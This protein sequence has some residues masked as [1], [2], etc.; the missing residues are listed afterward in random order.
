MKKIT[1][2]FLLIAAIVASENVVNAASLADPTTAAPTPPARTAAKV[3][4]FF[5]DAYAPV[6]GINFNPGWGQNTVVSTIQ[7]AGNNTLKY[8]GLNYQGTEFP[9]VNALT[10]NKL[11]IDVWTADGT[12]LQITPISVGPKENLITLTP[13]LKN[14]WNS[15]D[16]DLGQFTGVV[17]SE[18]FQFKIVG[19]GTVY[20]DNLYLYDNTATVD[21]EAPTALTAIKGAVTSD[22][23]ELL[24]N[25]T[26]NSGAVNF[27]ITYGTTKLTV[28]GISGV[29]KSYT[30]TGLL[31]GTDYSFSIVAK[32]ITGNTSANAVI[33]TAKTATSIAAAPTPTRPAANVIS[34][35]SDAH[36]NVT[37]T[38]FFPGWGQSTVATQVQ[39]APDNSSLKYANLNYQGIELGSHVNASAMSKLHIDVYTENE[40]A[41]Q[42]TPISTGK[43]FLVALS[44]LVLNKWNSY[45]IPL[46]S[47][48]GVVMSD[49]FQFK[50]VGSGVK[51]VY[52]D[53]LY[54]HDGTTAVNEVYAD[55]SIKIYPTAVSK[56]L[57]IKSEKEMSQVLVCN[58]LGQTLK[59]ITVTGLEKTI[60][61]SAI[62]AGNYFITVK[63]TTGLV[64]TYKIVK[65]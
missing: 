31:G 30:V 42:V 41:L 63:L 32:D 5:S 37:N 15:Y 29:Q 36:T 11:H 18:I 28:G 65:L 47:F 17:T 22:A 38:N 56:D 24:L 19:D 9:S 20:I 57:N 53:N 52:I 6:T 35:F 62:S 4:S 16:L 7:V 26:D 39:L 45:D 13:L 58:L 34:I 54:F 23:V 3:I 59:I 49:V 55:K 33:V 2:L 43:E 10:M 60:D 48:T 61:L 14:A 44:P 46:S 27:E 50:F 1:R 64:S 8:A 51:T 12:T 25:A 21:T 40:T